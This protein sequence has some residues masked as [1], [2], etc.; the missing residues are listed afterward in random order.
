MIRDF[1]VDNTKPHTGSNTGLFVSQPFLELTPSDSVGW[2]ETTVYSLDGGALQPYEWA[3]VP[4]ARGVH[5]VTWRSVDAASNIED[6]HSGTI[7][8]GP[9]AY[10][11]KP[12]GRS[13]VRARR[14]LTF[15]GKLTRAANH[16]RLTLLAYR[17]NG[18]DWVLTRTKSVQIHT[19]RRRGL[20]SYR[21]SI[22]FTAKGLW[23]VV[24]RYEGDGYWVQSYSAAKYVTVK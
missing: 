20:S 13:S 6:W 24:A 12:V 22:K 19:P 9:Q 8:S 16:K 11:R 23:K 2:V 18:V 21:G 5:T 10:V 7:I 4:L 14:S 1:I 3:P 15:S 17:F